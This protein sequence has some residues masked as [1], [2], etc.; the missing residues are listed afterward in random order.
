MNLVTYP[1]YIFIHAYMHACMACIHRY[2]YTYIYMYTYLYV[3][4]HMCVHMHMTL[5]SYHTCTCAYIYMYTYIYIYVYTYAYMY[6][7]IPSLGTTSSY[8]STLNLPWSMRSSL[9]AR[10]EQMLQ[11]FLQFLCRCVLRFAQGSRYYTVRVK[12]PVYLVLWLF[13]WVTTPMVW[14][15]YSLC[16]T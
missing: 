10:S 11:A 4:I 12:V 5:S 2:M 1:M 3:Y 14:G 9:A 15:K 8:Y 16:S 6:V 13:M 7:C